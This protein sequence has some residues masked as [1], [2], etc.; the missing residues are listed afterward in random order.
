MI[1]KDKTLYR[2]TPTKSEEWIN[3]YLYPSDFNRS[4]S[5]YLLK[6]FKKYIIDNCKYEF[7]ENYNINEYKSDFYIPEIKLALKF[8][9]LYDYCELNVEKKHQLNTY[10]EYDKNG[11]HIIQIFEDLWR[12]KT[13]NVKSRLLNFFGKSE[14]IFA[15]NCEIIIFSKKDTP[16]VSN[17]INDNH[18]QG[19][20]GSSI[21]LGLKYNNEIVSVMTFGK[22]RKN[23]GQ[24]SADDDYELLR[25]CN[26]M[27]YSVVGGA[28]KLFKFFIKKYNPNSITSYADMMWSN[29]E[30]IYKKLG[31]KFIHKSDPS[32]FY[33]VGN[34]RKNRF[35]YRKDVL[36]TCGY[37]GNY[38][39]EHDICYN[40]GLYRIFDVGTEKFLWKK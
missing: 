6:E 27:N 18:L 9:N 13:D 5:E 15:R 16:F 28:S 30:N 1:L 29:S 26:K 31:M 34:K 10:L 14:K 24:K 17:F 38:W 8:I 12:D 37:D 7:I 40:N 32:Y 25:F 35:G 21:K 19:K 23:L 36:L 33:I 39:G 4:N 11:I 2:T 22:L 20:I 3:K